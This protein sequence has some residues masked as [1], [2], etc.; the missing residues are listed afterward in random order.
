MSAGLKHC[1][2]VWIFKIVLNKIDISGSYPEALK[3]YTEA[4][5]RNPGDPKIYSNRAACY[6]KLMEF[7]LALRDCDECISLDPTFSK[8]QSPSNIIS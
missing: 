7:N 4:I 2:I 1:C 8:R 3:H 5:K 6:T